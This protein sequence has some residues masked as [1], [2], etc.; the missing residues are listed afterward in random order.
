[1]GTKWFIARGKEKVGPHSSAELKELART[2]GLLPIDM[3][4]QEGTQKWRRASEVEGLF[5]IAVP[6]APQPA[7]LL[8]PPAP[9][10][11]R[12][13]EAEQGDKRG[14][15]TPLP[16]NRPAL[17]LIPL[18]REEEVGDVS[19]PQAASTPA[20]SPAP[21]PTSPED[22]EQVEKTFPWAISIE[23]S[24]EQDVV[25]PVL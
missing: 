2:G 8:P 18:R 5:W 13:D 14:P 3:V 19:S 25:T 6:S 7:S 24:E 20:T 1:M 22:N 12:P 9:T 21:A 16:P 4:L 10:P 23:G 15:R 11:P 17:A